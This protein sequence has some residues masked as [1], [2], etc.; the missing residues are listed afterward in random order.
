MPRPTMPSAGCMNSSSGCWPG[1][2]VIR[3]WVIGGTRAPAAIA[4]TAA[5][6]RPYWARD[7]GTVTASA[8]ASASADTA[9]GRPAA[10]R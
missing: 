8:S 5:G 1:W 7:G 3:V 4:W 10:S 6:G 2:V 9:A